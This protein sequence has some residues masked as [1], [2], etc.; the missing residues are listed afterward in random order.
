MPAR[1][2]EKR[3]VDVLVEHLRKTRAVRREVAHYEKRIDVVAYSAH[4]NS[5]AGIEAKSRNW[6]RALQQAILNLTAVDFS[7]VAL[8]SETARR[9]DL[10]VLDEFGVGL[11]SVGTKWGDVEVIV[12]ARRSEF[13]NRYC[14]KQIGEGFIAEH[15]S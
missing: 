15:P 6:A 10:D 12:E 14:R 2:T 3:L 9:L 1:I 13:T 11:I 4:A 8:W 5:I 7:Y